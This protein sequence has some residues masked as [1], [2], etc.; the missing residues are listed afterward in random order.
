MSFRKNF[1]AS[2]TYKSAVKYPAPSNLSYFWN[3]GIFSTLALFIQIITGIVLVMFYTPH[4]DLAFLS[5]EHITRDIN[6]GWLLRYTHS[7][8]ASLFF[9]AIYFHIARGLIFGSYLFPRAYLWCS[10]V[11]LLLL[12]IVTAFLG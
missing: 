7:N 4:I 3:F 12:T 6:Y 1:F 8:G 11:L 5:I 10:G 9:I 2:L